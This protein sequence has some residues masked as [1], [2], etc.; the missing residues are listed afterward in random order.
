MTCTFDVVLLL[1]LWA[2]IGHVSNEENST[3]SVVSCNVV[4]GHDNENIGDNW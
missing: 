4:N 1:D 3:Y 2:Y